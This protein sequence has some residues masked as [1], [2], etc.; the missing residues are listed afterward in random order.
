MRHSLIHAGVAFGVCLGAGVG[1]YGALTTGKPAF[2]FGPFF[3]FSAALQRPFTGLAVSFSEARQEGSGNFAFKD[4]HVKWEHN[5]WLAVKRKFDCDMK[6]DSLE[7]EMGA[8]NF[9]EF[10][11]NTTDFF[12]RID[13][14]DDDLCVVIPRVA[15]EG[16]TGSLTMLVRKPETPPPNLVISNLQVRGVRNFAL[17]DRFMRPAPL[18]FPELD[19][20]SLEIAPYRFRKPLHTFMFKANGSGFVGK[21]LFQLTTSTNGSRTISA[22]VPVEFISSFLRPPLS[23]IKQG[24]AQVKMALEPVAG[25][26][27]AKWTAATSL[28]LV[29]LT[30]DSDVE[31]KEGDSFIGLLKS[32]NK[33]V[34]K[35]YMTKDQFNVSAK[36]ECLEDPKNED[37]F[38]QEMGIRF[39]TL[40]ITNAAASAVVK[41]AKGWFT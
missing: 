40:V 8:D 36:V 19:V 21:K 31:T 32:A 1:I 16:L 33:D 11:R 20:E 4:L 2:L 35:S 9:W 25:S 29:P 28:S 38:I 14:L 3:R 18:K 13:S 27:P 10:M 23:W 26:T 24:S 30:V 12:D 7:V 5:G 6:F 17:A 37:K 34:L 39:A 15:V 41:N 22:Q